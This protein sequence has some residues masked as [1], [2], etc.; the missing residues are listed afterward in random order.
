MNETTNLLISDDEVWTLVA[1]AMDSIK[2]AG[3]GPAWSMSHAGRKALVEDIIERNVKK[4]PR[5]VLAR[6]VK[7]GEGL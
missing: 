4:A 1:I 7:G 2:Q 5:L 6:V 3:S